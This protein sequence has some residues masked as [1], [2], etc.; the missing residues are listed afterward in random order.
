MRMH[1][2]TLGDFVP[3]SYTVPQNPVLALKRNGMGD[4]VPAWFSVPQNP[5]RGLSG[6]GEPGCWYWDDMPPYDLMAQGLIRDGLQCIRGGY[7]TGADRGL[8][9]LGCGCGG[10]CGGKCGGMGAI[11]L[12]PMGTG[13]MSSLGSSIGT[14]SLNTIP[15]WAVYGVGALAMYL[16]F[17]QTHPRYSRRR[18]S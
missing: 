10:G 3:G 15:N 9:G 12:S 1:Y 2:S 16:A 8:N 14:T 6:L 4:F 18:L 5:V 7:D 11:D 17:F 13:I